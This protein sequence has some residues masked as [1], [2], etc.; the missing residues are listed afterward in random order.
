MLQNF[1]SLHLKKKKC[2][3]D[4]VSMFLTFTCITLITFSFLLYTTCNLFLELFLIPQELGTWNFVIE[5]YNPLHFQV[6]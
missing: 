6:R 3:N 4:M 5:V 2:L 1:Y